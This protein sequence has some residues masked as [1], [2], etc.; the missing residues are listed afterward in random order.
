MNEVRDSHY[1]VHDASGELVLLLPTPMEA[2]LLT[3]VMKKLSKAF[4]GCKVAMPMPG[5]VT[6]V[7]GK[8]D[9]SA[10]PKHFDVVVEATEAAQ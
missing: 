7:T 1:R 4:P 3:S 2:N 8:Y 9:N 5:D 10:M 6:R